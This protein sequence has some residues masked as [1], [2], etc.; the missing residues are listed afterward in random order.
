MQQAD[1]GTRLIINDISL[2]DQAIYQCFLSND[3]GHISASTLIK[4][5]SFAPKFTENIKNQTVYSDSNVDLSCGKVDGS[6]K[7]KII[8]TKIDSYQNS[9]E[10]QSEEFP[11][12]NNENGYLTIRNVN[13]INQG[14]YI[15]EANNILGKISASMFLQVKKR[16]KLLNHQ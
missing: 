5:I 6:P 15:C 13:V 7:P 10:T 11:E 12:S 16:P 9:D 2:K 3:A 14:W 4:I 1:S 8:W